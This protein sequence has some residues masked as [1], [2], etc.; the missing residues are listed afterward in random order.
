MIRLKK[1]ERKSNVTERCSCQKFNG[2]WF[3]PKVFGR[4]PTITF[5]EI[6]KQNRNKNIII[7]NAAAT[8]IIP[9]TSKLLLLILSLPLPPPQPP[10]PIFP[11]LYTTLLL[12]LLLSLLSLLLLLETRECYF[13]LGTRIARGL[14]GPMTPFVMVFR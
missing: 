4:H 13:V 3:L 14:V 12:L 5:T 1:K 6:Q 11:E 9:T 7:T 10:P 2:Y 8:T